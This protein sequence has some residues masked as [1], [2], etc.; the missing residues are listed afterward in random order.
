MIQIDRLKVY[1]SH[2]Y[3]FKNFVC[4]SDDEK[5]MILKWRNHEKVRNMMVNKE[6]I[7]LNKHLE[8]I[9]SLNDRDDCFYWLVKDPAGNNLGVL[10]ISHFNT[11]KDQG[12]IGFYLNPSEVGKGFY[13]MIECDYFVFSQL[14]LK[15]NIV[16]VNARNR[17]IL[18]FHKFIGESFEIVEKIGDETFFINRHSGGDYLIQQYG[19]MSIINYAKFVKNNRHNKELFIIDNIKYGI[20]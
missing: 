10:D 2:G 17:D 11:I 12:E 16:T 18:L 19:E 15:N 1:E 14:K 3:R 9:K 5:Q 7:P 20:S 8:F 6:I 13:F 4:L